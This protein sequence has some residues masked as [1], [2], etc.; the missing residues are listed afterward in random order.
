MT[1]Y[2]KAPF[3]FV[4]LNEK[5]FFPNW[6]DQVSHDIPFSDGESGVIELELE[7]MTPIFVRNGH[8]KE[9]AEAK[10]DDYISFSKD[11]DGNYFIPAT[12]VKGMIR[13]VLEIISFGK[14]N[15]SGEYPQKEIKGK[16]LRYFRPDKHQE[17]FPDLPQCIFGYTSE[18]DDDKIATKGRVHFSNAFCVDNINVQKLALKKLTLAGPKP[19][20]YPI[21]LQ[22]KEDKNNRG[23]VYRNYQTFDNDNSILSGWKRYPVHT[24]F[25]LPPDSKYKTIEEEKKQASHFVAIENCIFS[26]KIR[27]HNLRKAEIGALLS[28][29]TFHGTDNCFH[30]IGSAKAYGYGKMKLTSIKFIG[31]HSINDYLFEFEDSFK[32]DKF[33]QFKNFS[34]KETDQLNELILMAQ[35]QNNQHNSLLEYM[36]LDKKEFMIA[37]KNHE[38]L[39]GYSKLKN[40]ELKSKIGE[41][42]ILLTEVKL[43]KE[44]E[45]IELL[46]KQEE[47]QLRIEIERIQK[48]AEIKQLEAERLESERLKK[49]ADEKA[50]IERLNQKIEGGL[51]FLET[52]K[53]FDDANRKIDDW[54]KKA[55]VEFVPEN[56]HQLLFTALTRFYNDPKNR[57][58]K[59]W[60]EPFAKNP[61]WK[62]IA[63]WVG[64]ETAL[65]W[66]NE[67]INR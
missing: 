3:N 44:A 39:N 29:I 54:V 14:M 15:L 27:F 34:L 16:N 17:E 43:K 38:F 4:P 41:S 11:S 61:I 51:S 5:V 1:L 40:I 42:D 57:D 53:H 24:K 47:E 19:S 36:S 9:D 48:E 50:R 31:K 23:K 46:R 45:R 28:A 22:Q 8:T 2:I 26:E 64:N 63:S 33:D 49:E 10:N 56:Q 25:K 62:K 7:A 20:Y 67:L 55:S 18:N 30:Y 52:S 6:A 60:K 21:Y 37:K 12:S 59:K 13:N 32:K 66:Y 58:K 65:K 35:E